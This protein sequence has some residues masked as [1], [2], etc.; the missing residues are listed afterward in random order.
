MKHFK[1][2]ATIVAAVALFVALGGSAAAYA[3]GLISG[4][5]IKNH[6]IPANK[7]TASAIKSLHGA[8]GPK[9]TSGITQTA[10]AIDT[11]GNDVTALSPANASFTLANYIDVIDV[12]SLVLTETSTLVISGQMG[13]DATDTE[14]VACVPFVSTSPI[15][16]GSTAGAS[17]FAGGRAEVTIPGT[18]DYASVPIAGSIS[19]PAGTYYV[20]VGCTSSTGNASTYA[21]TLS[22]LVAAS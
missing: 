9:G 11:F 3:T 4:S 13:L 8:R 17:T 14:N 6:S 18:G 1:H 12:S 21:G 2:P 19:E 10:A 5:Q 22:V 16:V 15:A 7:L 20:F